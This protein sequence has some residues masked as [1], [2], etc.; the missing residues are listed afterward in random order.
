MEEK[1]RRNAREAHVVETFGQDVCDGILGKDMWK[2]MCE[3][4]KSIDV[5]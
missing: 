1:H 5:W 4:Y 3:R 2:E